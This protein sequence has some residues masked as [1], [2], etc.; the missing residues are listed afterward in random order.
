VHNK[1]KSLFFLYNNHCPSRVF[2]EFQNSFIDYIGV[3]NKRVEV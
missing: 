1:K 2:L 3:Y